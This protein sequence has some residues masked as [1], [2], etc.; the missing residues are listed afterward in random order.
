[1]TTSPTLIRAAI[2][3]EMDAICDAQIL[4]GQSLVQT[5]NVTA[6]NKLVS[7]SHYLYLRVHELAALVIALDDTT[8]V[9]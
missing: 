6:A 5:H 9:H 3:R 2:I 1:M 7:A 4:I 8:I